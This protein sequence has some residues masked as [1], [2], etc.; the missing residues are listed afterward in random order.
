MLQTPEF[1]LTFN[2]FQMN[3]KEQQKAMALMTLDS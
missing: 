2:D 1:R 3:A